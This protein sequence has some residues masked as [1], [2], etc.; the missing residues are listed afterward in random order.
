MGGNGVP[1]RRKLRYWLDRNL[2]RGGG[3]L[4][5]WLTLTALAL[6]V[7][8][9][10]IR[11]IV[12]V[13]SGTDGDISPFEHLWKTILRIVDPGAVGEDRDWTSRVFDL[14]IT[15]VGL[16][17]ASALV[18]VVVSGIDGRVRELRRGRSPVIEKDHLLILGW[19]SRIVVLVSETLVGDS[20]KVIVILAP[21]ERVEMEDELAQRVG[22]RE[23][24]RVICRSGNPAS[25]A[26]LA[27]AAVDR[28]A[29]IAIL[30][31]DDT[32]SDAEVLK[33]V[34]A[35]MVEDPALLRPIVVEVN[36]RKTSDAIARVSDGRVITIHGDEAV[37]RVVAQACRQAGLSLV[38]RQLTSYEGCD[39]YFAPADDLQGRTFQEAL[40]SYSS[41][42]IGVRRRDGRV[43]VRP[44]FG[45]LLEP[46]DSVIS[47]AHNRHDTHFIGYP[48]SHLV[49][50]TSPP[51]PP[52]W[53][54]QNLLIIGWNGIGTILLDHLDG[55]LGTGS[56][57][58][59]IAD[60]ALTPSAAQI[61]HRPSV[62]LE[63][64]FTPSGDETLDTQRLLASGGID[65]ILVLGY[66]DAIS[67]SEADARTILTLLSLRRLLEGRPS[68]PRI[69]AE[70]I[71]SADMDLIRVASPDDLIVSDS[72]S[73]T[74][75]GQLADRPELAHVFGDLFSY[76]GSAIFIRPVSYFFE[77]DT[78]TWLET[79][80]QVATVGEIAIGMRVAAS[81]NAGDVTLSPAKDEVIHFTRDHQI[82][83]VARAEDASQLATDRAHEPVISGA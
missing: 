2:L 44:E 50:T 47:V 14:V 80:A 16:L 74:I 15:L 36:S 64:H 63:M 52:D 26:D 53:N 45:M 9:A 40:L 35:L 61:E 69:I 82:V 18:G 25:Q 58:T 29:S 28:A 51:K 37:A 60:P 66:R 4:V 21:R 55:F 67:T 57:V 1:M 33:T 46:G 59:V 20:E 10:I 12:H 78:R 43:H 38:F 68:R 77:P 75:M 71:D 34:L 30:V 72:L 65:A 23:L 70:L 22:S 3:R 31:G 54:R 24:S 32:T 41:A 48:D 83:V 42:V 49:L 6:I 5:I 19:S 8:A 81:E 7:A 27:M 13:V 76:F 79:V 39:L 62:H 11:V 73:A 17:L 56:T